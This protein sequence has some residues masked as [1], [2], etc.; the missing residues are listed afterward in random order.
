[1]TN[2]TIL[3]VVLA[4]TFANFTTTFAF[5][6]HPRNTIGHLHAS[7]SGLPVAAS[8]DDAPP[9]APTSSSMDSSSAFPPPLTTFEKFQRAATFWSTAIPILANYY[10]LIGNLKLQE[11]LGSPLKEDDVEVSSPF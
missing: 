7:T 11:L 1:M 5:I 4:A 9:A 2:S 3:F 10:G 8:V 6:S